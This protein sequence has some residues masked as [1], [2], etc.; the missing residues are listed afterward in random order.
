M[1]EHFMDAG[2]R[3]STEASSNAAYQ[4]LFADAYNFPR[5]KSSE[6]ATSRQLDRA[7]GG[8]TTISKDAP[9]SSAEAAGEVEDEGGDYDEFPFEMIFRDTTPS[10]HTVGQGETLEAL[11]RQHL[12][13]DAS[14]DEVRSHVQEIQEF[15]GGQVAVGQQIVLPGHTADGDVVLPLKDG[16]TYTISGDPEVRYREAQQFEAEHGKVP[17]AT[18]Q[19]SGS[20][21]EW[22]TDPNQ[23]CFPARVDWTAYDRHGRPI[24]GER[25]S[26]WRCPPDFRGR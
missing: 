12:G 4:N 13:R 16:S 14:E 2:D 3:T 11:A 8:Q 5:A 21:S 23:G 7:S 18:A 6:P 9:Y 25:Y 19:P 1:V 17:P 24:R 10:L 15:N 22:Q 26:Y 20:Q